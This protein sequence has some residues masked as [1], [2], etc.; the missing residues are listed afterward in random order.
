[1][2]QET[3]IE[4]LVDFIE[5]KTENNSKY[6]NVKE[7]KQGWRL[8]ILKHNTT[9]KFLPVVKQTPYYLRQIIQKIR[10]G[11]IKNRYLKDCFDISNNF[12]LYDCF[13]GSEDDCIKTAEKLVD[14]YKQTDLIMLDRDTNFFFPNLPSELKEIIDGCIAGDGS[15]SR[16]DHR[17]SRFSIAL[18]FKQKEHLEELKSELEKFG[19]SGAIFRIKPRNDK[20]PGY[21]LHW[22]LKVFNSERERWY[23]E[24]RKRLPLDLK[25][26]KNFWRWFY[27]GDGTL[28]KSSTFKSFIGISSNDLIE[29]D[30]DRLIKMLKELNI[31][32]NKCKA[33]IGSNGKQQYIIRISTISTKDFLE[34]IGPPVKS[35]EYKWK[36][37]KSKY[38][39]CSICLRLFIMK[40]I[41]SNFCSLAC[42]KRNYSN[43]VNSDIRLK[44]KLKKYKRLWYLKNRK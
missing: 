19:Y 7:Y 33:G 5:S 23:Y 18:G 9:K 8:I 39:K 25:N 16:S 28:G 38:K 15:I 26:S 35:L 13:L 30:V 32:A 21:G 37:K 14:H 27:A 36:I 44:N 40:R 6:Q 22:T 20:N 43:K 12:S 11:S 4:N 42:Q 1:M 24:G 3:I 31:K 41:S 17:T 34:Y 29:S 10:N 2:N